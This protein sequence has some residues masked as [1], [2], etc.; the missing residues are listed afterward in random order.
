MLVSAVVPI[1][2]EAVAATAEL[3]QPTSWHV[4]DKVLLIRNLCYRELPTR[5]RASSHRSDRSS[6]AGFKFK[7]V[8]LRRNIAGFAADRRTPNETL[9]YN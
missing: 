4:C 2:V 5:L 3:D 1:L 7:T 6:T 9:I 8:V